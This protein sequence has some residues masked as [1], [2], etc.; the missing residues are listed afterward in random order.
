[1]DDFTF[2]QW[3]GTLLELR[4]G[5]RDAIKI[6][7]EER[8][9]N[10]T[11]KELFDYLMVSLDQI[12]TQWWEHEKRSWESNPPAD[13][14]L[15]IENL[16]S[17]LESI[18]DFEIGA[19]NEDVEAMRGHMPW[20]DDELEKGRNDIQTFAEDLKK[21][22]VMKIDT[23]SGPKKS[24][25]ASSGFPMGGSAAPSPRVVRVSGGSSSLGLLIMFLVGLGLGSAGALFFRESAKEA[26]Q[27]LLDEREQLM[28][29]KKEFITD[30]S[31]LQET[32]YQ[33]A[34]GKLRTIPELDRLMKPIIE[35]GEAKKRSVEAEFAKTRENLL[36]KVPAGD[37]LDRSLE[38]LDEEKSI[39]LKAIQDGV[40]EKI[41]P[42]LKEKRLH[43][44]LMKKN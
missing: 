10:Y 24:A 25:Q 9:Q 31:S 20:T 2:E 23:L 8:G 43:E 6:Q 35:E 40:Q 26:E 12:M 19:S 3:S 14:A 39:R 32:Y 27:K 13:Q 5:R 4:Q 1:M 37:R 18:T 15:A 22:Y 11:T 16:K 17:E 21:N 42:Y 38:K 30:L 34:Q 29:E 28:K 7:I 41:E 44:D 33:L 36:K